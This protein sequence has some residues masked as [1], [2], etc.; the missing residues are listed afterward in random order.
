MVPTHYAIELTPDLDTLL[1]SGSEVVDIEVA[2]PTAVITLNA[3]DM[4]VEAA[5]IDDDDTAAPDAIAFHAGA[6]T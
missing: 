3:V 1:I 5:V 4:S 2:R 6:Q